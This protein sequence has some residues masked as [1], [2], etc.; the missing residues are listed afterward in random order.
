M[1]VKDRSCGAVIPKAKIEILNRADMGKVEYV[2]T[3]N[4]AGIA[5][6]QG[7]VLWDLRDRK[8]KASLDLKNYWIRVVTDASVATAPADTIGV[9]MS[10]FREVY[11]V[12]L[13]ADPPPVAPA[14]RFADMHY[15]FSAKPTN[16]Y[17]LWELAPKTYLKGRSRKYATKLPK[18]ILGLRSFDNLEV[19]HKGEWIK[20]P[21]Q[22]LYAQASPQSTAIMQKL[23]E[24]KLTRPSDDARDNNVRSYSQATQRHM[25]EGNVYLAF[26]S[27]TPFESSLSYSRVNRVASSYLKSGVD[28]RFLRYIGGKKFYKSSRKYQE[29]NRLTNWESFLMEHAIVARQTKN[30]GSDRGNWKFYTNAADFRDNVPLVVNVVEGGHIFQDSICPGYIRYNLADPQ[31]DYDRR[32]KSVMYQAL[33]SK[34]IVRSTTSPSLQF[35]LVDTA[36]MREIAQNVWTMK[37]LV[38]RIHMVTISH[39][40][41]NGMTGQGFGIDV[42]P[43]DQFDIARGIARRLYGARVS[44]NGIA[45]FN[46]KAAFYNIPG[47]NKYGHTM[48]QSLLSQEG[49]RHR[50]LIDLKHA[51]FE[52]RKG[53]L[54]EYTVLNGDTIP[55]ICSHCAV[56]GL[57]TGVYSPL[58]NHY[59]LLESSLVRKFNPFP[60]N[61]YDEEIITLVN[62]KGIIGIPLEQRVLGGYVNRK[63]FW[64]ASFSDF[65]AEYIAK[66]RARQGL[67]EVDI[68]QKR[69]MAK[70]SRYDHAVNRLIHIQS[71]GDATFD[72][73]LNG[74]FAVIA[75]TLRAFRILAEDYISA[76][77]FLEN[78]FHLVDVIHGSL[79]SKYQSEDPNVDGQIW[80]HVCIG[81]DLDGFIDPL[82]ICPTAS[83]YPIFKQKL[84]YLIPLF[85]KERAMRPGESHHLRLENYFTNTSIDQ[86]LNYLFYESLADFTK[87]YFNYQ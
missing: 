61:L 13:G 34:G 46:N 84:K 31:S 17:A 50:V 58:V 83:H 65:D 18:N 72:A 12:L 27:I 36:I 11:E 67:K 1:I 40:G 56:T 33:R 85:L 75:D 6:V 47:I 74:Q 45:Q 51:D 25:E 26:N 76:L 5:L 69:N 64:E 80:T 79:G 71:M 66:V 30:I 24:G 49:G 42:S 32:R 59:H 44:K 22:D 9:Q 78:L 55:P 82:D 19:L 10:N 81:S 16:R 60:I 54:E 3:T 77:P 4:G 52:T 57:S 35:E 7:E 62:H 38:P 86:A 68:H 37:G 8:N 87:T 73:A 15:H 39:L 28:I 2:D 43:D 14:D 53:V 70:C 20:T 48:I 23:V 29:S 41:Y 21:L 63:P